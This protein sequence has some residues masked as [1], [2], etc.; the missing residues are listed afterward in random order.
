MKALSDGCHAEANPDGKGVERACVG[1][2]AL[3]GLLGRLV[4]VEDDGQARHEEE[5][6]HHPELLHTFL[7]AEGLPEEAD[8]AEQERQAVEDVAA[9][10]FLQRIGHEV[11]VAIEGVVDEG[12]ACDGIAM[13]E[14]AVALQV[15]LS[16]GEVP[17]EVTPVH[18]VHLIGQEEAE[19]SPLRR[20]Y[21]VDSFLGRARIA[22]AIA[23]DV[24]RIV[25]LAE[26][27]EESVLLVGVFGVN[28]QPSVVGRSVC[29]G[30]HSREEHLGAR[31][32]FIAD[33]F[34]V[35]VVAI[36][37]KFVFGHVALHAVALDGDE[38][39]VN[40]VAL[41]CK[42]ADGRLAQVGFAV[43]QRTLAVLLAVEVTAQG[44]DILGGVLVHRRVGRGAH[45]DD[46]VRGIAN[47]HHEHTEQRG[48]EEALAQEVFAF[49]VLEHEQYA[50]A[51]EQQDA[52]AERLVAIADEGDA[53]QGHA[54]EVEHHDAG[55]ILLR[56]GL[57]GE[58]HHGDKNQQIDNQTRVEGQADGVDEEIFKFAAHFHD[59]RH[60]AVEHG[61]YQQG[62][63]AQS[64]ER[65][66]ELGIRVLL[67]IVHQGD[68]GQAKQVEQVDANAEARQVEDKHEPAVGVRFIGM[69]LPFQNKPENEG[70]KHRT[71]SVNLALDGGEPE[72]V[73]PR[74]GKGARQACTHNGDGLPGFRD[75]AILANEFARQVRDAPEEEQ[76]TQGRQ[77]GRH[78]V[79]A[80]GHL[81]GVVRE[82]REEIA[83]EHEE[84]CSRRMS[85]L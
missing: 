59:A 12:E 31:G 80:Q 19:V 39:L 72:R 37:F 30:V 5:E 73:A 70:C 40:V 71:I 49:L 69:V 6:E 84:G 32:V 9:L 53:Q 2:V 57:D 81:G 13:L 14:F 52:Q 33:G 20:K 34:F 47:H 22:I 15:V 18:E 45:H 44:E 21:A 77:Q 82:E 24:H 50:E 3:A 4:E 67:E 75:D 26:G 60:E 10:V 7:S 48:V 66:L 36:A 28:A 55:A 16:A 8:K 74:I 83:C 35:L 78:H 65:T 27:S 51:D 76:D 29:A 79:D 43:E 41:A 56:G 38:L 25:R 23:F 11:L 58:E 54:Q 64:A 46:C 62:A 42:T 1:I 68:G 61:H 63:D 17:Q 85:H